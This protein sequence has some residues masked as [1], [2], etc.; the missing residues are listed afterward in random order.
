MLS[1]H[2]QND[3]ALMKMISP[4]ARAADVHG[5][6]RAADVYGIARAADVMEHCLNCVFCRAL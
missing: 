5:M 2:A 4:S 1:S 3:I 6:A